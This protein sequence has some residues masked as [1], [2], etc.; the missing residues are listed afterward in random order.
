MDIKDFQNLLEE[1]ASHRKFLSEQ[2]PTEDIQKLVNCAR[3]APN[4]HNFQPW[5]FIAVKNKEIILEMAGAIEDNL[6]SI[7][8]VLTEEEVKKLEDYKFFIKHFQDA[9]LVIAVL[10][11]QNSYVSSKLEIKYNLDLLRPELFNMTLLGVGAA[12]NNLLLAAESMGYGSCWMTEPVVYGQKSIETILGVE[13]P[14][15]FVS[16]IAIGK[17]TKKRV[18]QQRKPVDELLTIKE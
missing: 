11:R 14:Y 17:P 18:G 9:P 10:A 1:R 4:G 15:K 5:K 7:Y 8:T 6:K 12:V 13:E 16:L 3:L 2:I